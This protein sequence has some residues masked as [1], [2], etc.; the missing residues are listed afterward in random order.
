M[1]IV[2]NIIAGIIMVLAIQGCQTDN[3]KHEAITE[4]GS[5][6]KELVIKG[7][8]SLP[9]PEAYEKVIL[10]ESAMIITAEKYTV[11]YRWID[12]QEI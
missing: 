7:Q 2:G 6:A 1:K 12:H 3:T 5:I 4:Q 10:E 8:V 11:V 9:L